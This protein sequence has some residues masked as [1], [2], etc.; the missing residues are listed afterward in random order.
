MF[1]VLFVCTGNR[2]RS[3]FAERYLS[4]IARDLPVEVE[5]AGILD[6]PGREVPPELVE[7]GAGLSL[8]R[9]RS[10]FLEPAVT[11]DFDLVLGFE[12]THV[13]HAVVEAGADV[14]KTFT[15]PEIV[16]LLVEVEAPTDDDFETYA[17]NYVA[18][19]AQRRAESGFVPGE[20]VAD[21]FR[22]SMAE[23]TQSAETIRRLCS[24]LALLLF[25]HETAAA[26]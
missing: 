20:E 9:H 1:R 10:R 16:R 13:A 26:R 5:S 12:G 6:A 7:L 4:V 25:R 24:Q 21:P 2:C 23:Y 14:E 19:A 3:P 8:D 11:A 22:R 18:L 17:R 15:L